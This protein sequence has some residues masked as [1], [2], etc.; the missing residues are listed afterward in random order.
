MSNDADRP[1]PYRSPEQTREQV[2]DSRPSN[3]REVHLFARIADLER[4]VQYWT[5]T[6]AEYA[7]RIAELEEE[8][9]RLGDQLPEKLPGQGGGAGS[10]KRRP[11]PP[12]HS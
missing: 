6:A 12:A 7:Q 3:M 4:D 9:K 2:L 11:S 8:V 5:H 1:V 10:P